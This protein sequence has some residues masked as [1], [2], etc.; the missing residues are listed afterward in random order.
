MNAAKRGFTIVELLIVIVVIAILASITLVTYNKIQGQAKNAALLSA[1]DATAKALRIYNIKYG[2]YP[3]TTDLPAGATYVCISSNLVESSAF[4]NA[5]NGAGSCFMYNGT[6]VGADSPQ[7]DS[8]LKKVIASIPD[9]SAYTVVT[10]PY[11]TRGLFYLG[12]NKNLAVLYYF[13]KGSQPCGRG[14]PTSYN[15]NATLCALTLD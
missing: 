9:T 11:V 4:P 15:G 10:G 14:S 7:V 1:F 6:V 13:A 5:T 8:A 12:I 3:L 2:T